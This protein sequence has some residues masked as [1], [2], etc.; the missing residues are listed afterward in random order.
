MKFPTH[1]GLKKWTS[2][3]DIGFLKELIEKIELLEE[4]MCY[5]HLLSETSHQ[6]LLPVEYILLLLFSWLHKR[7][8]CRIYLTFE[9]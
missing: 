3:T 1:K 5:K 4:G 8:V 2:L 9:F 6:D 7:S